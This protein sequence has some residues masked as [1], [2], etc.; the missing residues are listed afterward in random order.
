[1]LADGCEMI[2]RTTDWLAARI[3]PE[4]KMR[5]FQGYFGV[6]AF[7]YKD[8]VGRLRIKP[9]VELNPRLTMG[10]IALQ[11][12]KRLTA[13]VVGE[14]RIL[15]KDERSKV[16]PLLA[17]HPLVKARDGRWRSGVVELSEWD[18]DTKLSPVVLIGESI[19]LAKSFSGSR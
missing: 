17:S 2:R 10:H 13:G 1:M 11:L 15:S 6:D 18:G 5:E 4:L 14:F 12:E 7:A 3:I 16:G 19:A 8:A 9:I